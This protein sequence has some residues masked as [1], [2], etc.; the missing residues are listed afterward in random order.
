MD[1]DN[2]A[3]LARLCPPF[4]GRKLRLMMEYARSYNVRE[5]PDPYDAAG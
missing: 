4:S 2:R 3:F 5:V 1:E